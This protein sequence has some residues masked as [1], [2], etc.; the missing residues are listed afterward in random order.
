M[1]KKKKMTDLFERRIISEEK[2]C[3]KYNLLMENHGNQ[4]FEEGHKPIE[5]SYKKEKKEAKI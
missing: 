2:E 1:S 4:H 3:N 5:Q